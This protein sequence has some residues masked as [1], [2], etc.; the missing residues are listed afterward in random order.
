[1]MPKKL[2]VDT[3]AGGPSISIP[4]ITLGGI[5]FLSISIALVSPVFDLVAL[6]VG[7]PASIGTIF[8]LLADFFN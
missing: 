2:S 5:A 3:Q 8:S 4:L 6:L 7:G 1:M